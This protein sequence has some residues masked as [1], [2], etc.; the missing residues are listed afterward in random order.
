MDEWPKRMNDNWLAINGWM[1]NLQLDKCVT[2][3]TMNEWISIK[4][5]MNELL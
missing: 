3:Q 4:E 2:Y 5:W 1:S